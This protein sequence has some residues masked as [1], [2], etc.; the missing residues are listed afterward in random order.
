VSAL[1]VVPDDRYI[2]LERLSP[3]NLPNERL[4]YIVLRA[5][6]DGGNKSHER[7]HMTLAGLAAPEGVWPDFETEWGR[8]LDAY[9][10]RWWHTTDAMSPRG[11]REFLKP[12]KAGWNMARAEEAK[13]SLNAVITRSLQGLWRQGFQI[14]T[15]T[16][17]LDDYRI[18]R[19]RNWFLRTAEAI[20][21]SDCAGHLL[22]DE[23][24]L[25][26][27]YFDQGERFLKEAQQIWTKDLRKPHVQWTKQIVGIS[28]RDSR[29]IYPLQAADLLA[30]ES[31][32]AANVAT[33]RGAA[34]AVGLWG[35]THIYY[36]LEEIEAH[37]TIASERER[38]EGIRRA[39]RRT[40]EARVLEAIERAEREARGQA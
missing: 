9:G 40:R 30:W 8:A 35:L 13:A 26:H 39:R 38:A 14:L 10:L 23:D 31:N 27:L 3:F 25:G 28:P 37:Y 36:D 11:K 20:C 34:R 32:R 24:G 22:L 29:R 1:R 5:Y 15:C 19:D 17:N 12:E 7:G 4:R 33:E 16:I 21:V 6:Y 18:A 2:A